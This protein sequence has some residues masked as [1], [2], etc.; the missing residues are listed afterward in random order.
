[1]A[2]LTRD[3]HV[4]TV[5]LEEYFQVEAFADVVTRD[6]WDAYPS[7][8]EGSTRLLLDML[9]EAGATATFFVLGWLAERHGRLV[10]HIA[11]RGHE[12]ACHSFWHRLAYSLTPREFEADARLAKEVIE[13]AAG[14]P[15]RGY[16]APSFSI[17]ADSLW[18]LDALASCGF[19]YDSSIFPIHHDIYGYRD[20]PRHPFQDC[21]GALT[22]CP[23]STFRWFGRQN[24]PVGGGAYLRVLPW[25]YTKMG[26]GRARAEGIPVVGYVHPW[27]LDPDQPRIVGRGRSVLRHYTNLHKTRDRLRRL[28]ALG[29]FSSFAASGLIE[30]GSYLK[31]EISVS[32]GAN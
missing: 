15:V 9:D 2:R 19:S 21:G 27:E 26:V 20:A 3:P 28:L 17:T 13:Q 24:W 10:R 6:R 22:V 30:G 14:C 32:S 4:F 11:E 7:R 18:V 23:M 5:D 31:G 25:W 29:R 8:L 1:M 16:R 12:V